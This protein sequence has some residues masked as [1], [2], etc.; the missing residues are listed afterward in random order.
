MALI[1]K[2]EFHQYQSIDPSEKIDWL[3]VTTFVSHFKQSFDPVKQATRS[4]NNVRSKWYGISPEEIQSIWKGEGDRST[5]LGTWYHN[6]RESDIMEFET[7]ERH[8]VTVPIVKPIIIEGIKYAPDQK[9]QNGIYPEHL[10]YLKSAGICGQ[11]D[12]VEVV[13]RLVSISDYKTSKEIKLEGFTNWE[14]RTTKMLYTLDHLDDCHIVHYGLQLSLY[15]YMILKHNPQFIP[16]KLVI[17]HVIFE[18]EARDKYNYPIYKKD[19]SGNYVIKDLKHYPVPYYKSEVI[20]MI[21]YLR[22]NRHLI[23]VKK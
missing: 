13:N 9:L 7:M 23:K 4:S 18:E 8:G 11:S 10:V 6:Q 22:D 15:L 14:G 2:P 17:D 16:G 3:G 12:R 1:F 5:T 19:S 21:N 20:A